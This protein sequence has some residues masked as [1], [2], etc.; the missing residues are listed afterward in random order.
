MADLRALP[1][2][3]GVK[4]PAH[5]A[6]MRRATC[7]PATVVALCRR[8]AQPARP[9]ARWAAVSYSH[10][11]RPKR[12][13]PHGAC[14]VPNRPDPTKRRTRY[15][16]AVPMPHRAT[17]EKVAIVTGGSSGIGRASAVA[18]AEA[19]FAVVLAGRRGALL[20]Q[21][22]SEI[23]AMRGTA[24]GIVADVTDERSV[25]DLFAVTVESFG[26]V[27]LLF[28]NAGVNM[29]ATLVD[30]VSLADWSQVIATNVT[31]TFLCTRE[32]FRVMR[33]QTPQGGRIINNGSLSAHVPRP[34]S[35]AYTASKH[36]VT[37]MTRSTSL[38]G[39]AFGIACGQIDIGN[40]ATD[41]AAPMASGVLQADG[42]IRPEPTMP[43]VHVANAV[44]Y[45]ASL[46]LDANVQFM[47]VMATAM[48]Y[49]G[50]G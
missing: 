31:G 9:T 6:L 14:R 42:D 50:R 38:D 19:G 16:S 37:G 25:A 43:A 12:Q 40:A 36:A 2:R 17:V 5:S 1:T 27:D 41:L 44:V 35:V 32:A 46:P 49:I 34:L 39:R 20:E 11:T 24:I 18:L 8:H 47:T 30:E 48:P 13:G 10:H 23:E 4:P 45:M 29:P 28:N 26:R 21:A 7:T 33:S 22:R 3:T 15:V